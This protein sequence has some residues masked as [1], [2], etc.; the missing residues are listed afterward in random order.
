MTKY[1]LRGNYTKKGVK[2]LLKEGGSSRREALAKAAEAYGG[3]LETS[4]YA[5]GDDDFFIIMDLPDNVAA[6]AG[7][8]MGNAPGT[9]RVTYTVLIT[10]EEIDQAVEIANEKM[11]AYRPPGGSSSNQG[12]LRR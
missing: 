12:P 2:G 4:Y 7:S 1:L 9:A 10:P 5:F 8:M 3:S 6:V 11:A